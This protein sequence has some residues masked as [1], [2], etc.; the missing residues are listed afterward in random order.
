VVLFAILMTG[1]LA[2]VM[3]GVAMEQQTAQKLPEAEWTPR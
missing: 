3:S 1:M 2:G